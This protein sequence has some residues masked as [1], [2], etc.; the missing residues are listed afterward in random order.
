MNSEEDTSA[1][2]V[3]ALGFLGALLAS[4]ATELGKWAVDK[5]K[6]KTNGTDSRC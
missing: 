5:L 6:E 2:K 3:L 1:R 4:V